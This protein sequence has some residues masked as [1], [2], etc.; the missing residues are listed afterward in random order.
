MRIFSKHLWIVY[1]NW[2]ITD[3]ACVWAAS[4]VHSICCMWK[5]A[6]LIEQSCFILFSYDFL[7]LCVS[8]SHLFSLA[9]Y[10]YA[11]LTSPESQ[12]VTKQTLAGDKGTESDGK[13]C[14]CKRMAPRR[15]LCVQRNVLFKGTS[16]N[17]SLG[18]MVIY[19]CTELAGWLS[20]QY[21]PSRSAFTLSFIMF[22]ALNTS[23]ESL[24]ASS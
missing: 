11:L 19:I 1:A 24:N 10:P 14:A 6:L 9:S 3:A 2:V 21:L 4:V 17:G 12:Y 23:L 5:Q 18:F 8:S 15:L 16:R 13:P 22:P 7:P 20:P